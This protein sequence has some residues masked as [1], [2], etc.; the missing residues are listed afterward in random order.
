ME[1]LNV[2]KSICSDSI[3]NFATGFSFSSSQ[4]L[5]HLAGSH[6]SKCLASCFLEYLV[7]KIRH[8]AAKTF[9]V[10]VEILTATYA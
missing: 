3:A 6:A 5:F 7:N 9:N 8:V 4:T 10:G 2:P 1:L